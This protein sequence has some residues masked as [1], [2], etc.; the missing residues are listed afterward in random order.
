MNFK[1]VYVLD[2]G[3]MFICLYVMIKMSHAFASK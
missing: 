3:C 1:A 2:V